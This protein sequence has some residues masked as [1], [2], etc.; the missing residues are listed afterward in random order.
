MAR[1]TSLEAFPSPTA[2][3]VHALVASPDELPSPVTSARGAL[4]QWYLLGHAEREPFDEHIAD[5]LVGESLRLDCRGRTVVVPT[6][7]LHLYFAAANADAHLLLEPL[8]AA[9]AELVD[10]P[11]A[12]ARLMRGELHYREHVL[13]QGTPVR[14]RAT[15]VTRGRQGVYRSPA[16]DELLVVDELEHPT[17]SVDVPEFA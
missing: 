3:Y 5:G 17:L 9:L 6:R 7:Y 10:S 13:R 1:A 15:V 4:I 2:V 14:L 12:L 8:P 16:D 11:R